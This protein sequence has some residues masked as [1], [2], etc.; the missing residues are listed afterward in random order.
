MEDA[1]RLNNVIKSFISSKTSFLGLGG[2]PRLLDIGGVPYLI[3]LAN[4]TKFYN[5]IEMASLAE[6]PRAFLLGAGAGSS[7]IAGVNCEVC[8]LCGYDKY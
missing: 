8:S 3:P 6:L 4:K 2:S 7:R 5:L 1:V